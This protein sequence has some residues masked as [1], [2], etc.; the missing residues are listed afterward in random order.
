MVCEAHRPA[1]T[2]VAGRNRATQTH[3]RA[4]PKHHTC[5]AP[6]LL[7]SQMCTLLSMPAL[8]SSVGWCGLQHVYIHI[9]LHIVVQMRVSGYGTTASACMCGNPQRPG[10]SPL[11]PYTD[12][13][14]P[15]SCCRKAAVCLESTTRNH[16]Q[17]QHIKCSKESKQV[18]NQPI[19]ITDLKHL[20]RVPL[21]HMQRFSQVA[22][23][24]QLHRA[25]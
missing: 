18:I 24:P 21:Q 7:M 23:V 17:R 15:Q 4:P 6:I 13:P 16:M 8:P 14:L 12:R 5:A 2:N 20:V 19:T 11:A 25:T 1:Q 3:D 22:P 9:H 10:L